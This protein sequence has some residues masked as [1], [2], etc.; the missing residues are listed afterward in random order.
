L[1]RVELSREQEAGCG[2]KVKGAFR[3]RSAL[4]EAKT[5]PASA[6]L[7][8][9][10]PHSLNGDGSAKPATQ[11]ECIPHILYHCNTLPKQLDPTVS[12]VNLA[13]FAG[14]YNWPF[15]LS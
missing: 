5:P 8:L 14:W 10:A 1:R 3:P 4:L 13:Q 6:V 12:L 7:A 2:R 11:I 15:R 9:M